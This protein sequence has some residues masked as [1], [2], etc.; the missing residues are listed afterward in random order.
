M[1][2][3]ISA[4]AGLGLAML[5]AQAG[6]ANSAELKIWS[7]R[8]ISTVLAEVGKNFEHTSGH[9]LN[10]INDAGLQDAYVKRI[11]AGEA[12]DV[13]IFPPGLVDELIK[14][15]KIVA[16]TRTV[17]A[18][19]GVGVAVRK[20]APKP[21]I[22]SADAFKR[23]LIDAKSIAYLKVGASGVQVAAMLQSPMRSSRKSCGRRPTWCRSWLSRAKSSSASW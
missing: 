10:V 9:K 20:G 3:R 17:I 5:L 22:S 21:D 23:A 7:A 16:W 6:P 14:Q 1:N 2:L 15:G 4:M 18:R 11:Q 12:F 19:S 13:F 8:A